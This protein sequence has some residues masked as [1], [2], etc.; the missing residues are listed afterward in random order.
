MPRRSPI[1]L[2][3]AADVFAYMNDLDAVCAAVARVLAPRG[4]FAFTVET[5][6]GDGVIV[7]REDALPARRRIGPRAP[8]RRQALLSFS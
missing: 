5:H 1:G 6:D 4:W 8:S 2:V 7:G 3:I